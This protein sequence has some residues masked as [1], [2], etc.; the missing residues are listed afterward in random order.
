[1]ERASGP[2]AEAL[3]RYVARSGRRIRHF[4]MYIHITQ[5]RPWWTDRLYLRPDALQALDVSSET[6]FSPVNCS[7]MLNWRKIAESL[8]E[9]RI[10]KE[11]D[12]RAVFHLVLGL[13]YQLDKIHYRVRNHRLER[14][15]GKRAS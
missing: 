4:I 12:P 6:L 7:I 13:D 15:S 11:K 1:L 14:G 3:S 9:G 8:I 2:D 10:V 5:E